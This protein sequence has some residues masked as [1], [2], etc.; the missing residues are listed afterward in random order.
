M[1]G[2]LGIVYGIADIEG[3]IEE[4]MRLVYFETFSEI[5]SL[6]PIGLVIGLFFGFIFGLLRAVE[7]HTRG[8]L[9][10]DDENILFK[11]DNQESDD[12]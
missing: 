5:M 1:G 11:P 10:I 3:L 2:G 6:T 4:S 12:D 7:L 9:P 8:D